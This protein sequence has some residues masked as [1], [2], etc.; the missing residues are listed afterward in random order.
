M[1]RSPG[2]ICIF[3]LAERMHLQEAEVKNASLYNKDVGNESAE[4]KKKKKKKKNPFLLIGTR[5]S[6]GLV[7]VGR[8][9][10][11]YFVLKPRYICNVHGFVCNRPNKN[12][13]HELPR[14]TMVQFLKR[15]KT[16]RRKKNIN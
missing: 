12:C 13:N 2:W 10:V 15:R 4:K 7:V 5:K 8:Q 1:S 14:R 3:A 16:K 6:R 9:I 11:L